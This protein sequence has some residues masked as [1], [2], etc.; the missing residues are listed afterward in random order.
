MTLIIPVG[1]QDQLVDEIQKPYF[2]K[3]QQFVDSERQ[4]HTIFPPEEQVFAALD[5]TPLDRVNVLILGQDPYHDVGQAHGLCFSV[6]PGIK[7]PPSLVNIY[8]ELASDVGFRIPNHGYL[9]PWAEQGILMLNAVLT[10]RVHTANSHKNKG[11]ETFTDAIIE[12]VN[13]KESPVVFVLW[14]AY[15]QKKVKLI[16]A[17]R[18]VIIQ[19]AHPS[20][21]SA[22]NGFFGSRPFSAI[23]TALRNAD[24]PEIDW[25]L[26]DL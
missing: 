11:W 21:L 18:H 16:D 19:S 9:T 4:Q 12:K 22:R 2:Q 13:E 17:Q 20:P 3:L 5:I 7:T 15:A 25:Q 23:N 8:K 14:G 10:V 1:W 6:Q 24:K 26:S